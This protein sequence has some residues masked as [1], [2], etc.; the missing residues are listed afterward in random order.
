MVHHA[1]ATAGGFIATSLVWTA[2]MA[3]MMTPTVWPWIGAYHRFAMMQGNG[4][5]R[6]SATAAFASGYVVAWA[7]FS[8]VIALA[9]LVVTVPVAYGGALLVAAGVFQLSPLKH[10]CLSHCR[11]PLSFLLARWKDGPR[12]AF[13]LGVMHG[14]YC[15]GCCWA[16]MLTACAAGLMS[17][18]WMAALAGITFVE[19]VSPWGARL[20]VPIGLAL[21]AMGAAWF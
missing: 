1:H 5:A 16:L 10:A 21:I 20:R 3:V 4:L 13:Q 6:A 17:L 7:M 11:N 19:Q 12:S 15:V 18:W 8:L 14:G 9:H 2:M